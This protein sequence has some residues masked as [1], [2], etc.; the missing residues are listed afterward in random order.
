[1]LITP[2]RTCSLAQSH[3][4]GLSRRDHSLL[5][6]QIEADCLWSDLPLEDV[7]V[8][9]PRRPSRRPKIRLANYALVVP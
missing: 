4:V 6:A 1:M 5:R 3:V 7:P 2:R 9:T 8:S